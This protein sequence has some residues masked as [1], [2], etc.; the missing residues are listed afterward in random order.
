[1]KR[2]CPL[3]CIFAKS[4]H[5]YN[6]IGPPIEFKNEQCGWTQQISYEECRRLM[7]LQYP[8]YKLNKVDDNP[9][10]PNGC[11]VEEQK[12]QFRWNLNKANSNKV[13]K[14][15]AKTMCKKGWLMFI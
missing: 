11:Y 12:K 13:D 5:K 2:K 9:D 15:G 8:L 6:T 1:M 14:A 7:K 10:M 3:K 4:Q